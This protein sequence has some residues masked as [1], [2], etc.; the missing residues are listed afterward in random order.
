[1]GI[2]YPKTDIG[3]YEADVRVT[4]ARLSDAD[5]VRRVWREDYTVWKPEPIEI[6]NPLGWL[7]V[8][9]LMSEQV[10]MLQSFAKD[11]RGRWV[12]PRC[13]SGYGR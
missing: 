5:I 8:T 9:D 12:A 4:L 7:A 2:S 11:V 6:T 1:M 10:L 3:I 13:S